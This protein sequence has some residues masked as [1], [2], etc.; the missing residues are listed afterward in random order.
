MSQPTAFEI[1]DLVRRWVEHQFG[2]HARPGRIVID[3]IGAPPVTL[4][5]L[6]GP[7][8][9]PATPPAGDQPAPGTPG[10][11][12]RS[13]LWHG[14]VYGFTPAQAKVVATLWAARQN[15]RPDVPDEQLIRASGSENGKLDELFDGSPAWGTFIT[16]GNARG[17]HRIAP[18]SPE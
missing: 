17:T 12:F 16:D 9:V 8:P 2:P 15:G 1:S 6:G 4:P 10:D 7:A 11:E 14:Q 13:V 18:P 3:L 5:I